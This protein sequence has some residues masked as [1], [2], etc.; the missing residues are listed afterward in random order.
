[1]NVISSDIRKGEYKPVYLL[2]GEEGFLRDE[3]VREL[4]DAAV[5]KELFDFNYTAFRGSEADLSDIGSAIMAPPVLSA[6]RVVVIWDLD[7]FSEDN[8]KSISAAL[9]RM[10]RTTVVI[11]VASTID[12]RTTL[13]KTVSKK[14][15]AVLFRRLY[16]NQALGWL[17]AY[18]RSKGIVMDRTA[19]EYLVSILGTDLAQLVAGLERAYDYSGIA[20]GMEK[21]ITIDHVRGVVRGAP[22]L[23]VFDLVDGIG[24]RNA[25]KAITSL[26]QVLSFQEAPLRILYLIARQVRLILKAKVLKERKMS[27]RQVA[28]ALGVQEFVARKCLAQ[29][30]NFRLQ[31]LENAFEAM[32]QA[33][34]DLKT[35]G[36]SDHIILERLTLY[37]C[38]GPRF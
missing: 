17:S 25:E 37:L 15:R 11:L 27:D 5:D 32:V 12:R 22:E 18:T 3:K 24:E 29:A 19:R 23:G 16:P 1:M 6:R 28:K 4:A 7:S 34:M 8:R 9:D 31:E 21:K 2:Y 14:G 38:D 36:G 30:E 10:P 13:F 26:R 35:S 20:L 33:D